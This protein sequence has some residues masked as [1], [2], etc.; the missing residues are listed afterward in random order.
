M[1][2]IH[3]TAIIE[4]GATIGND[5]K[6]GPYC[7]IGPQVTLGDGVEIM[8][9]VNI[10]GNT[11]IGPK[12]KIFPFA[13]LGHIPQDLKYNGEE[14]RLEIGSNNV[15]R[16]YVTINLG[17]NHGGLTTRVDS[18]CLIMAGCHIAHDCHVGSHVIM[19]N[20]VSLGGHVEV[21]DY[22]I[23]GG[24]AAVHQFVRIGAHAMVGG[25]CGVS[26]DVI[27]YGILAEEPTGLAGLN[28]IGLKRR[29]FSSGAINS[30]REAY[31]ALFSDDALNSA[32]TFVERVVQ[33][34]DQFKACDEVQYLIGFIRN[35]THRNICMP[36]YAA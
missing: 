15:I 34:E 5:V 3:P 18:H 28:L 1:T 36:K 29:G 12:T 13:S 19:A 26:Q 30:L 25:M 17:T 10:W 20:N 6:I 7:H 33:L 31:K 24:H 35:G 27:P 21:G 11:T 8:S 2:L 16:E 9:H 32:S 14:S 22:A 23:L 4:P